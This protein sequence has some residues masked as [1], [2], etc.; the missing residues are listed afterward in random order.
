[1][2][3]TILP[4]R[5]AENPARGAIRPRAFPRDLPPLQSGRLLDQLRERI[6]YPHYNLRA[7]EAYAYWCRAFIRFHGL[8]HPAEMG[9]PEVEAFF[10]ALA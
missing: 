2:G 5:L 4:V 1:V 9:R 6:R 3:C 10:S 8:R 7:E